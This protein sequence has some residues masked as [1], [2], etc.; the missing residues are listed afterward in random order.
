MV[1]EC[2]RRNGR[3]VINSTEPTA[4]LMSPWQARVGYI[5][6]GPYAEWGEAF[7]AVEAF[8][9]FNGF[10]CVPRAPVWMAINATI[11][12]RPGYQCHSEEVGS[13]AWSH[14][15]SIDLPPSLA[16]SHPRPR[17][18][19]HLIWRIRIVSMFPAL[20]LRSISPFPPSSAPRP[21]GRLLPTSVIPM[22]S[23]T[24]ACRL[25]QVSISV[26]DGLLSLAFYIPF[27]TIL[28]AF[29][30]LIGLS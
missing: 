25:R 4:S 8:N 23:I 5:Y 22:A 13:Y 2:V 9:A 30:I 20:I 12:H 24:S 6:L 1:R 18:P 29:R 27:V 17:H 10:I 26:C 28:R 11:V 15:A 3:A 19:F 7:V 16:P 14:S 21:H